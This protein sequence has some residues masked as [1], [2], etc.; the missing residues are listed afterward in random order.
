[1]NGQVIIGR[2]KAVFSNME[3]SDPQFGLKKN[4]KTV[5]KTQLAFPDGLYFRACQDHTRIVFFFDEIF[6]IGRTVSDFR[7]RGRQNKWSG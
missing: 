1:V 6:M 5:C 7:H 4:A 3:V 2:S